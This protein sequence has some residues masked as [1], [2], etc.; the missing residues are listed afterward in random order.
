MKAALFFSWLLPQFVGDFAGWEIGYLFSNKR[1]PLRKVPGSESLDSANFS[2]R[3]IFF[4]V[5]QN[6]GFQRIKQRF[7]NAYLIIK[8]YF[9]RATGKNAWHCF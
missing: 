8:F 5:W 6:L 9:L 4:A 3:R 7:Q 2:Q 1:R